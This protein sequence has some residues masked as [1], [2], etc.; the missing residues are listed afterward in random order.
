MM[1]GLSPDGASFKGGSGGAFSS[2]SRTGLL[3]VS[4]RDLLRT[5]SLS[6]RFYF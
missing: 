2:E 5:L 4:Y 3:G 1:S 6:L